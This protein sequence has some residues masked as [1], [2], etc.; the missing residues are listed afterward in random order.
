MNRAE[1]E[2]DRLIEVEPNFSRPWAYVIEEDEKD[3]NGY[4]PVAVFEDNPNRY[5]MTGRGQGASPWYWGTDI[6][7]AWATADRVNEER[8]VDREEAMRIRSSS[9]VASLRGR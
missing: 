7:T 9:I 1:L 6:E 5:P 2:R 4:I 3:E 8:G